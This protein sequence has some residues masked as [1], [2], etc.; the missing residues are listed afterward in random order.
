MSQLRALDHFKSGLRWTWQR[1]L[2]VGVWSQSP[3]TLQ[4]AAHPRGHPGWQARRRC[5]RI[6]VCFGFE[7]WKACCYHPP[8]DEWQV[9]AALC[10]KT[11]TPCRERHVGQESPWQIRKRSYCKRPYTGRVYWF[12]RTTMTKYHALGG[13]N[14]WHLSSHT[15]EAGTPEASVLACRG[16]PS[17]SSHGLSSVCSW[18]LS[19]S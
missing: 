6:W 14:N 11:W 1:H 3:R 9:T 12:A 15:V 2:A 4:P 17:S 13:L 19:V 5:C 8:R 16:L 7:H 10:R 18:S